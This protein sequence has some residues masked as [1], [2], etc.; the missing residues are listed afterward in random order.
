M[1][2]TAGEFRGRKI[3][4][5]SG[6][7]IR[8]TLSKIRQAIFNVLFSLGVE[9]QEAQFLELFAGT[10]IMSFESISRGGKASTLVENSI[11]SIKYIEKNTDYLKIKDKVRV[12]KQ[13]A[14]EF[15]KNGELR[16]F[17][18]VFMDPPYEY[19]GY[20]E[21]LKELYG[22]I[23]KDAVIMVESNKIIVEEGNSLGFEV[24][25]IKKWGDTFVSFL[26]KS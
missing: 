3:D 17:D 1:I 12:V 13:D 2:I 4:C 7:D 16:G 21:I 10:G 20:L 9:M 23:N 11:N 22:K 8:P 5:P 19:N 25:K 15:V 6:K 24:I 26:K 14:L 18:L